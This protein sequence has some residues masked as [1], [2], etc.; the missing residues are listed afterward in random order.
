MA[1]TPIVIS[2]EMREERKRHSFLVDLGIRL[3]REK[4]L[5]TIG[6]VITLILFL[7]GIFANVL[8]SKV[9]PVPEG[10][11]S[12]IFDLPISTSLS[13]SPKPA[14]PLSCWWRA[15]PLRRP[16]PV[17]SRRLRRRQ[18]P[19]RQRLATKRQIVPAIPANIATAKRDASRAMR[20]LRPPKFSCRRLMIC[21]W[22][23]FPSCCRLRP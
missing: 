10:P 5:G 15:R 1:E 7:T 3:V 14:S 18:N 20:R 21:R 12:R 16:A 8:A 23:W 11:M 4:P 2:A 13:N 6:G 19:L 22:Q 17:R 9:F